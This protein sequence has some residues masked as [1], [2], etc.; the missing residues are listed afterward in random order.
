MLFD[1]NH[2]LYI[3]ISLILTVGLLFLFSR[4]RTSWAKDRILKAVG[5]LTV[6]IHVSSIWVEFL[7][8]GSAQAYPNILFPIFFCNFTMY[9][10]LLCGLIRKKESVAYNWLATFTA[11]GGT[12]GALISL[13][14]PDYYIAQPDFWD[15]GIFKSFLSHSTMML[16]CLYL[17]VGGYVKI[18]VFNLVPY[19]AGLLCAGLDGVII[20]GLFAAC[21]LEP[22]NAMFLQ[23]TALEGVPF[24]NGYG[25]AL[26]MVLL[27][28]LFTFLWEFAAYKK[29][30]RWYSLLKRKEFGKLL[31]GS[32]GEGSL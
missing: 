24:F 2:T 11:Y 31:T 15:W 25:I 14:Y 18:R 30:E 6:V 20:N 28:F 32:C 9:C 29:G 27:I 23:G 21:G 5:I 10:L 19:A 22:P 12:I 17:F 16:G 1:L 26:L 3:V 7:I 8:T 13:F 4:F